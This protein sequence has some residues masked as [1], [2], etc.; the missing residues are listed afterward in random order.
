MK[1]PFSSTSNKCVAVQLC[2]CVCALALVHARV[3]MYR[4]VAVLLVTG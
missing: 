2:V 3:C 4:D 1:G